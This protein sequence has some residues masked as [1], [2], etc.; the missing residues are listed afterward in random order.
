MLN[1]PYYISH[2][3]EFGASLKYAH[4]LGLY[5]YATTLHKVIEMLTVYS[6]LRPSPLA[7]VSQTTALFMISTG[8]VINKKSA[9]DGLHYWPARWEA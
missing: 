4:L 3:V 9:M 5:I 2:V 6:T 1:K 8:Q 7:L